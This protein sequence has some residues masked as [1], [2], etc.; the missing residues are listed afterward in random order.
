MCQPYT[1]STTAFSDNK[2]FGINLCK[3]WEL[4]DIFTKKHDYQRIGR[5][6]CGCLLDWS[7]EYARYMMLL[8]YKKMV[9][10]QRRITVKTDL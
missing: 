5:R 8:S 10:G 2:R 7:L 6:T 1:E 3:N 4:Q 9:E